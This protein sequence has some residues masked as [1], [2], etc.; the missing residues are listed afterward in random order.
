MASLSGCL[1]AL[2]KDEAAVGSVG[3]SL[4]V[5]QNCNVFC[6]GAST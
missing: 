3:L 2:A 5:L 4:S 6:M 1:Y